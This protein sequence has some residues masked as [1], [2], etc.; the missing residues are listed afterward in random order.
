MTSVMDMLRFQKFTVGYGWCLEFGCSDKKEHFENLIKYSPLHNIRVPTKDDVQY[1]AVLL[2]TA[3]HDD[4]VVPAH[5]YKY[6]AELQHVVG[7]NSK[8]VWKLWAVLKYA[9]LSNSGCHKTFG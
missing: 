4:R 2:T 3:D 5:S 1:P 6:A 9:D 8:Q 7:Q